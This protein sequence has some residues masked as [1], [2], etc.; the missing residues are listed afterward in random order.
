MEDGTLQLVLFLVTQSIVIVGAVIVAYVKIHVTITEI[1]IA[2]NLNIKHIN[3]RLDGLK[4]DHGDLTKK[5]D[6]INA[7]LHEMTGERTGEQRAGGVTQ[8]QQP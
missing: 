6:Q 3:D 5:V 7:A 2:M 4:L 1:R 8:G